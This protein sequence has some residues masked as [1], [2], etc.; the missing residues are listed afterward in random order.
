MLRADFRSSSVAIREV[1]EWDVRFTTSTEATMAPFPA[2]R[3]SNRRALAD[4]AEI[5]TS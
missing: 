5:L 2:N 4:I 1:R 3:A